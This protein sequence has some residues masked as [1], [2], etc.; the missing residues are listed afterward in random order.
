MKSRGEF[1][2]PERE[3]VDLEIPHDNEIE[4][5]ARLIGEFARKRNLSQTMVAYNA[6]SRAGLIE[7][8][9]FEAL[10]EDF[11][12]QWL[13][14]R[15]TQREFAQGQSGGPSYYVVRRHRIG[16]DLIE[17]VRRM[18]AAG[19]VSTSRAARIL[20]VNPIQVHKLLDHAGAS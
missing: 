18:M 3:L 16:N 1:M 5:T 8:S 2:L 14:Q 17:L 7:R 11:R 4:S 9:T 19:A 15:D 12:Q 20:G 10:S 13:H 6:Y